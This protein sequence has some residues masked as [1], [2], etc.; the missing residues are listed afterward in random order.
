[1]PS[2]TV[3]RKKSWLKQKSFVLATYFPSLHTRSA[4]E[5]GAW[6]PSGPRS[7]IS[8]SLLGI[9]NKNCQVSP[10]SACLLW[11]PTQEPAFEAIKSFSLLLLLSFLIWFWGAGLGE[12]LGLKGYCIGRGPRGWVPAGLGPWESQKKGKRGSICSEP[13]PRHP[14]SR[15]TPLARYLTPGHSVGGGTWQAQGIGGPSLSPTPLVSSGS[16]PVTLPALNLPFALSLPKPAPRAFY[17]HSLL[18]LVGKYLLGKL[19]LKHTCGFLLLRRER[20]CTQAYVL[21]PS[22]TFGPARSRSLR[23]SPDFLI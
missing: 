1:M 14:T 13:V 6:S 4:T 15:R 7:K 22:S 2:P 17:P 11:G 16:Q 21:Q 8:L 18:C 9:L 3:F 5:E 19:A 12:H 10:V 20:T 23:L